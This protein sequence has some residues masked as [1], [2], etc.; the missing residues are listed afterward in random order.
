M[1]LPPE[2]AAKILEQSTVTG[3]VNLPRPEPANEAEC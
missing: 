2:L 1:K 3:T